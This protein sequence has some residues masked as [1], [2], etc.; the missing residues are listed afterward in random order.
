MNATLSFVDSAESWWPAITRSSDG[1][2]PRKITLWTPNCAPYWAAID[3]MYRPQWPSEILAEL[4]CHE[5]RKLIDRN[6]QPAPRHSVLN[7]ASGTRR[8]C[9]MISRLCSIPACVQT[10]TKMLPAHWLWCTGTRR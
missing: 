4:E 2:V 9:R 7:P 8:V 1:V 3:G 5:T 6:E 10:F